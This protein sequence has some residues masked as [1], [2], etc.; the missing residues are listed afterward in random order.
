MHTAVL[1][2][3]IKGQGYM[4]KLGVNG[5]IIIIRCIVK[6]YSASYGLV[7]PSQGSNKRQAVVHAVM[8]LRVQINAVAW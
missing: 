7:N 6:T 3:D 5:I 4:K 8:N 1:L 2:G